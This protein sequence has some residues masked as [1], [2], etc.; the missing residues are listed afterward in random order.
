MK[1]KLA[2]SIT[3]I[4]IQTMVCFSQHLV[5]EGKLWSNTSIGTSGGSEHQSYWVKFQADT[6]INDLEYKKVMQSDDSLHSNWYVKG[7]IREDVTSQKVYLYDVYNQVD[8]LLYDFSLETGD[9]ILA[10]DGESYAKVD[11]VIYKPFGNSTD[12]LKQICFDSGCNTRWIEG[13]GSLWGVMEG[14]NAFFIT[15]EISKLVCY[16]DNDNLVYHNPEFETCFPVSTSVSILK[17]GNKKNIKIFP[18]PAS[19]K[20][21]IHSLRSRIFEVEIY[22]LTGTCLYQNL[23]VGSNRVELKTDKLSKGMYV[24]KVRDEREKI[25]QKMVIQ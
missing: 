3:F 16:Y 22:D 14:L 6:L 8:I 19:D 24:L 17:F 12:T 2:F 15:G 9:S 5:Q 1:K 25:S 10:G 13:I 20:I 7:F 23:N 4:V 18:N 21:T 11:T